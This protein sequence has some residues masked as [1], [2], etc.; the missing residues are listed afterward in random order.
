MLKQDIS[1]DEV[2]QMIQTLEQVASIAK[3]S[4][5]GIHT[6]YTVGLNEEEIANIFNGIASMLEP[7]KTKLYDVHE[8]RPRV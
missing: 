8:E 1:T 6:S 7:M 5:L 3:A 2:Y 4:H